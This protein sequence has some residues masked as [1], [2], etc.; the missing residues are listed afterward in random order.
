MSI[1]LPWQEGAW[2]QLHE[3]QQQGRLPHALLLTGQAGL[4]KQPFALLF[5]Q[6]L[7]CTARLAGHTPCGSCHACQLV[8]AGSHPDLSM[9]APE[10]GKSVIG[11]DR[12][13]EVG[14]YISLKSQ[15]RGVK[16]VLIAPAEQMNINAA[17]SL[18]KTLEEPSGDALL[19]LVSS[20]PSR[21]PATIRSR[22]QLLSMPRPEETQALAWLRSAT[23]ADTEVELLLSLADGAPLKALQLA[24]GDLLQERTALLDDL[25]QLAA[26]Q[27]DPV[28]VATRWVKVGLTIPL[29]WIHSWITDMIR[30]AATAH[31]P[32]ITNKDIS[33]RLQKLMKKSST[34][35]LF[36]QLH[37]V[38]QARHA[39]ERSLNPN[40]LFEGVLVEWSDSFGG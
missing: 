14:R 24:T 28:T 18:L 40:L 38:E 31:P 3:C 5:A 1:L 25:E 30:M 39:V 4:G 29:N 36:Q 34:Q 20:Y 10:E 35:K 8:A 9:V 23:T 12:I 13:R 17:N 22:C 19:I 15:Y 2:R 37:Q 33:Q 11:V 27:A 6:S 21:L 7:L 32:H 16:I 26:R